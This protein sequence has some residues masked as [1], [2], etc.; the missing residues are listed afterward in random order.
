MVNPSLGNLREMMSRA[1]GLSRAVKTGS[2]H[3]S[4]CER[5][6]AC[7]PLTKCDLVYSLVVHKVI[8]EVKANVG[9]LGS[10]DGSSGAPNSPTRFDG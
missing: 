5:T 6:L 9:V 4:A 8:V 1:D 7:V 3:L 2:G 10:D